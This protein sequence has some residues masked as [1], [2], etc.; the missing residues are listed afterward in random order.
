MSIAIKTINGRKYAYRVYRLGKK[1][2]QDYIGSISNPEVAARLT[3]SKLEKKVPKQ[4]Y[5]L[6]WDTNPEKID[7]KT[8]KKYIIE[9][10]LEYGGLTS[11]WWIQKIYPTNQIIETLLSSR[12]IS[13]KS[14]NFWEVWFEL[15]HA[16]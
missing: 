13:P 11:L 10:V 2:I 4:F 8:H 7:I 15:S 3:E 16:H 14:K 12:R 6:F 1:I 5:A 9:K